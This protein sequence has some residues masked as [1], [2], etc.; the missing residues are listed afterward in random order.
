MGLKQLSVTKHG[1]G[2]QTTALAQKEHLEV[3][4]VRNNNPV[5]T[6]H[7]MASSDILIWDGMS[8]FGKLSRELS[9]GFVI[10]LAGEGNY[11]DLLNR[12][13]AGKMVSSS[14]FLARLRGR[15]SKVKWSAIGKCIR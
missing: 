8:W 13:H 3:D 4:F 7:C 2:S 5:M 11:V 9:R 6:I 10:S 12:V 14:E 1:K 15:T